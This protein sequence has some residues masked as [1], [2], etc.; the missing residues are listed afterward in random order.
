MSADR[1]DPIRWFGDVRRDADPE[2]TWCDASL[3]EVDV[4]RRVARR[5]RGQ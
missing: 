3:R 2:V 4:L 1:S 5:E